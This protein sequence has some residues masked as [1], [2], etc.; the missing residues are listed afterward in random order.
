QGPPY[1][2][3]TL[4]QGDLVRFPT[5]KYFDD[6]GR[7]ISTMWVRGLWCGCLSALILLCFGVALVSA[8]WPDDANDYGYYDGDGDDAAAAPE[9]LAG[10]GGPRRGRRRGPHAGTDAGGARRSRGLGC[11]SDRP[12][13]AAAPSFTACC[14]DDSCRPVVC[15]P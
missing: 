4:S 13:V 7:N 8:A 12:A 3:R 5:G 10:V 14:I 6:A 11:P 9:A 2:D 1:P 15:R